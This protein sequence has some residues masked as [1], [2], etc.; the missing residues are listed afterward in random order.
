MVNQ[1]GG[2]SPHNK[3]EK[4]MTKRT[5]NINGLKLGF[6]NAVFLLDLVNSTHEKLKKED[7]NSMS[8]ISI[9]KQLSEY[10]A[11]WENIQLGDIVKYRGD[12]S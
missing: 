8:C 5:I 6:N 7:K 10:L 1:T 4:K 11:Q 3:R 12:Q 2:A 9:K